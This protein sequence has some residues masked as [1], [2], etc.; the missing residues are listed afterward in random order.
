MVASLLYSCAPLTLTFMLSLHLSLRLG[1]S[2]HEL[3]RVPLV[4]LTLTGDLH[5][6]GRVPLLES[7]VHGG[8]FY[9]VR[10]FSRVKANVNVRPRLGMRLTSG[11]GSG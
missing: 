5:E 1:D 10:S 11:S 4:T 8:T 6:L 3:G 9:E 2:L 7:C